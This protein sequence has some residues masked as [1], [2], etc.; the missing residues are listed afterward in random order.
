MAAR[1]S[2]NRTRG[3]RSG[4][5]RRRRGQR[6]P[7]RDTTPPA[8]AGPPRR[9][10]A[11]PGEAS[12]P[13][14]EGRA[15]SRTKSGRPARAPA[16]SSDSLGS[17]ALRHAQTIAAGDDVELGATVLRPRGLVAPRIQRT[18]LAE[19]HHLHARRVDPE[20]DQ[21][22]LNGVRATHAQ[23]QVVLLR[24]TLVRVPLDPDPDIR[25]RPQHL[26][27]PLQHR[28]RILA[29]VEAVEVEVHHLHDD[30]ART[31]LRRFGR[32]N[33]RRRLRLRLRLGRTRLRLRLRLRRRNHHR[34][35][36]T[37]TQHETHTGLQ[38]VVHL[39]LELLAPRIARL[40]TTTLRVPRGRHD[41]H[42]A[43]HPERPPVAHPDPQ[44]D[45]PTEPV[46]RVRR[47]IVVTE[48]DARVAEP[49][50]Q[51][52]PAAHRMIIVRP[53]MD[54]RHIVR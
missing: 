50:N 25:V 9:P 24:A 20:T 17:A 32:L 39:A 3:R 8:P 15:G 52:A 7:G 35:L 14:P 30:L 19:A 22:L 10:R 40:Q 26:R 36:A 34:S 43:V 12:I 42:R 28:L 51:I 53:R 16:I 11:A 2:A 4:P 46:L 41:V 5:E 44:P 18:V 23:R 54:R 37:R 1:I 33:P 21:V 31:R 6:P 49:E 29:D 38:A 48:V 47:T 45:Q 13:Y 27:L